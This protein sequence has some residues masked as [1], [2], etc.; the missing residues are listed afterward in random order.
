MK[1]ETSQSPKWKSLRFPHCCRLLYKD[2]ISD[3]LPLSLAPTMTAF[4]LVLIAPIIIHLS[5]H[6]SSAFRF[7]CFELQRG[8]D[9]AAV[10]PG[11]PAG[12]DLGYQH[13]NL[14]TRCSMFSRTF[15]SSRCSCRQTGNVL[16]PYQ[17]S[18]FRSSP[19]L[20]QIEVSSPVWFTVAIIPDPVVS[21]SLFC[22]L[23]H[24]IDLICFH[25]HCDMTIISITTADKAN[26]TTRPMRMFFV[27]SGCFSAN[28]H[29]LYNPAVQWTLVGPAS[30]I[31]LMPRSIKT[32]NGFNM[33]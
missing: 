23:N 16:S 9:R 30:Q 18:A 6:L 31:E 28:L 4:S 25:S 22:F 12:Y 26:S 13:S 1:R 24:A 21:A 3:V 19:P 33:R 27:A 15:S 17:S 10:N 32:S 5:L 7:S 11:L 14:T 8:L 20:L 2:V 29:N